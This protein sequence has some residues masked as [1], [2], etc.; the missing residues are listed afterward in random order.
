MGSLPMPAWDAQTQS[1]KE[2]NF[3]VRSHARRL[4]EFCDRFE[5]HS[6]RD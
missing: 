6:G 1:P 4:D 5:D 2:S 3:R